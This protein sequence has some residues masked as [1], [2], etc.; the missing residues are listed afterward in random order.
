MAA[1]DPLKRRQACAARK[2]G[3]LSHTMQSRT[4]LIV[5]LSVLGAGCMLFFGPPTS[6]VQG[7]AYAFEEQV[8]LPQ[9]EVCA[10]GLDTL[11]VRADGRGHYSMRL[12]E[13]TAVF[14]FRYGALAPA[15]SDT[16]RI[17]PPQG[18]TINCAL[19]NRMVLSDQPVACQPVQ[20][21]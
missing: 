6:R 17:V 16:V 9:A 13:Q 20:G 1:R 8:P 10:L 11:C 4:A 3:D 18:Y 21:R 12:T 7:W 5:A 2:T 15:A 19:S 14:R